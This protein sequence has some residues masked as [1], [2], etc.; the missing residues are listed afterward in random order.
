M[1]RTPASYG[2]CNAGLPATWSAPGLCE[3][4]LRSGE[5]PLRYRKLA[6]IRLAFH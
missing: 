1:T 5:S 6:L 3:A 2:V 4:R